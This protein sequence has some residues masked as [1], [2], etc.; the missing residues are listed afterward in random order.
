MAS[1]P[2]SATGPLAA[3]DDAVGAVLPHEP[4][5]RGCGVVQTA[6]SHTMAPTP[7]PAMAG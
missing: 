2:T 6:E 4:R 7:P 3:D 5:V 1:F